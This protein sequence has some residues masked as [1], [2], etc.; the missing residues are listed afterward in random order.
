MRTLN[1]ILLAHACAVVLF[2]A[3]ATCSRAQ[4][5]DSAS[6]PTAPASPLTKPSVA[7]HYGDLP[8]AFEP[9]RGQ[10]GDP[11]QF[12]SHSTGQLLLL[13]QN[14]AVLRVVAN[15]RAKDGKNPAGQRSDELKIR[16]ANANPTAEILP[17]DIQPGKSNYFLGN[18]PAK[19]RTNVENYSQV[20]YKSLYPGVDL[21][22]YGNQRMLEHDFIVQPGADYHAIALD[23][24]GSRKIRKNADGSVIIEVLGGSGTV[25]FSAP[26]IYQVRDGQDIDV[27]GGY[28]LKKNELAF[29]VG[30]YD[31]KL[32]LIIDPVL[33][34]S[35]YV[36]G[37]STDAAAGIA[38][39]SAGNAYITGYT[40][41][42][43][44]RRR[45]RIRRRATTVAMVRMCL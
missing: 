42:T 37:S 36:A 8:L 19:W 29:N 20:R 7:Q 44:F 45:T 22:F 5:S 25:R 2:F 15:P 40:F 21:L 38:L 14:Q 4:S 10:A 24:S 32:P 39:D 26:R 16:F 31:K 35:T 9:N 3:A 30:S 13:E 34:Y 43:D 6:A 33:S 18:D 1:R 28:R 41:S 12:L 17:L 23:I 27:S 11:V